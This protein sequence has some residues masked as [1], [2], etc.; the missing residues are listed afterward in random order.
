MKKITDAHTKMTITMASGMPVQISSSAVEP[1]I[2]VAVRIALLA[3]THGEE[4][5]QRRD[6]NR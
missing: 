5:D 1:W 4:Q 3:V 2:C 6:Q